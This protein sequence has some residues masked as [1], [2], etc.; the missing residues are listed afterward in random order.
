MLLRCLI[1]TLSLA[2]GPALAQHAGHAMPTPAAPVASP[3]PTAAPA[4]S[5]AEAASTKALR[6]AGMKM[7]KDMDVPYTGDADIDFVRGMIPHH[8]GAV[9]MAKIQLQYGKDPKIRRLARG[10]VKA[11]EKEIAFMKAYLARRGAQ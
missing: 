5:P 3:A 2:A 6:E 8:Q 1:V 10:I 11:Q 9:E 4:P 7:H